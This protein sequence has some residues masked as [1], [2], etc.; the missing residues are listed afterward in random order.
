VFDYLYLITNSCE[1]Q[2]FLKIVYVL[3]EV[4]YYF[5]S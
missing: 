5:F 2:N 1:V 3:C 4:R